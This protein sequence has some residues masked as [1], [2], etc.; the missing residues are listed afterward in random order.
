MKSRRF[1]YL[2]D[3]LV[4]AV[5]GIFTHFVFSVERQREELKL[6]SSI[7]DTATQAV[8]QLE[9]KLNADVYAL[10]SASELLQCPR[11]QNLLTVC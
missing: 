3:S 6:R 9:V 4:F 2:I 5:L 7:Q 8:T 1:S 11:R 10:P